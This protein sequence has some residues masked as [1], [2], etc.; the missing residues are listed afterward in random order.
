MS[1]APDRIGLVSDGLGRWALATVDETDY[2]VHFA[3]IDPAVLRELP[4]VQALVDEALERA[5]S[6]C[7]TFSD[8]MENIALDYQPRISE[9]RDAIV[10]SANGLAAAIR[11]MKGSKG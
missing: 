11:A 6:H 3:R 9:A 8:A 4:E 1:E 5:A 2:A 7:E 10:A